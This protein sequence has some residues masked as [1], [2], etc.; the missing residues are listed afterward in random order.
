VFARERILNSRNRKRALYDVRK[1]TNVMQLDDPQRA[2]DNKSRNGSHPLASCVTS[3]TAQGV[4]P[5]TGRLHASFQQLKRRTAAES[6]RRRIFL[7]L[8]GRTRAA[9]VSVKLA[10]ARV[11][12]SL[13]T[14]F[15]SSIPPLSASST[16]RRWDVISPRRRHTGAIR[17][18]VA[19]RTDASCR[20]L[21]H[22]LLV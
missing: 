22:Q 16:A 5:S 13:R 1:K 7:R 10:A 2:Q 3:F 12:A 18:W 6:K 11:P 15:A 9:T 20:R 21:C 17:M 8:A 14:F 4:P 19:R